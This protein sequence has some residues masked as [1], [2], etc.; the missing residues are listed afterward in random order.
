M[1]YI[2]PEFSKPVYSF[3]KGVFWMQI[4]GFLLLVLLSWADEI[5]SLPAI[6]FNKLGDEGGIEEAILETVVISIVG[7]ILIYSTNRLLSR[8][9]YLENFI[10]VCAWCK[11]IN[12]DGKMYNFEEFMQKVSDTPVTHG[13]CDHCASEHFTEKLSKKSNYKKGWLD[14]KR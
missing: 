8:L 9:A 14:Q 10:R 6:I 3:R 1:G 11:K 7:A 12:L 13:I 5:F 2:I 4:I